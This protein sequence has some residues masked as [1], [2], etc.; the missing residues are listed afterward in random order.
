M[1][2]LFFWLV[3]RS[4]EAF[5]KNIPNSKIMLGGRHVFVLE[6]VSEGHNPEIIF[7][8]WVSFTYKHHY[9]NTPLNAHSVLE[10]AAGEFPSRGA[11]P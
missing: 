1:D 2:V 10:G 5:K 9:G 6:V 3:K 11:L 8:C 7:C 4:S